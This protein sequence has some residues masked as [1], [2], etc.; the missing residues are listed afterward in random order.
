MDQNSYS[1][2]SGYAYSQVTDAWICM[3]GMIMVENLN[4]L[5]D[6][7]AASSKKAAKYLVSRGGIG[8]MHSMLLYPRVF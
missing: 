5:L 8:N 7:R 4:L 3:P 2:I 6:S 1:R